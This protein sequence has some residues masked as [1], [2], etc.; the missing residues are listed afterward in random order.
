MRSWKRKAPYSFM[1]RPPR[2][3]WFSCSSQVGWLILSLCFP[4][5]DVHSSLAAPWWWQYGVISSFRICSFSPPPRDT[6]AG[7]PCFA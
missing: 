1:I 6:A 7:C 4:K 3:R 5:S 2:H